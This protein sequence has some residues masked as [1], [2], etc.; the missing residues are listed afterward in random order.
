MRQ[1]GIRS[2][3]GQ[4][5]PVLVLFALCLIAA[6]STTRFLASPNLSNVLL[7]ASVMAVVTLGLT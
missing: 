6:L 2:L 4:Q 3:L 5:M 1:G 7:Q